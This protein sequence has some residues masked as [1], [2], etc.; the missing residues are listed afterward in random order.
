MYLMEMIHGLYVEAQKLQDVFSSLAVHSNRIVIQAIHSRQVEQSLGSKAP[1]TIQN[2][3]RMIVSLHTWY[4][5]LCVFIWNF[6]FTISAATLIATMH[7]WCYLRYTADSYIVDVVHSNSF[8][9]PCNTEPAGDKVDN[10]EGSRIPATPRAGQI[11]CSPLQAVARMLHL[12][13]NWKL[14]FMVELWII[15]LTE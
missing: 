4:L 7:S 13:V 11:P 2:T 6:N 12:R 1:K 15:L 5:D 8:Q 14:R 10:F 3:L 9:E